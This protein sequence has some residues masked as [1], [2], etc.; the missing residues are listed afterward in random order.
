M[1]KIKKAIFVSMTL[2]FLTILLTGTIVEAKQTTYT[3]SFKVNSPTPE[4]TSTPSPSAT[5][6]QTETIN[7]TPT[8]TE[9]ET[10][11]PSEEQ[12]ENSPFSSQTVLII[13]ACGIAAVIVVFLIAFRLKKAD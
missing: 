11:T 12:I 5:P 3:V 2:V 4:T 6:S 10:P 1:K 8:P 7:S 9:L 13:V